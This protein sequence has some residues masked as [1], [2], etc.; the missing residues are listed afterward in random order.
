MQLTDVSSLNKPRS[1]YAKQPFPSMD[2]RM[3]AVYVTHVKTPSCF[4]IQLIG[5]RTTKALEALQEDMTAFFNSKS[6]DGYAI[7]EP[8]IGQVSGSLVASRESCISILLV[9]CTCLKVVWQTISL[10]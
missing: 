8:Y 4:C 7:K 5:D 3:C 2:A 10:D 1:V 6:G 9:V